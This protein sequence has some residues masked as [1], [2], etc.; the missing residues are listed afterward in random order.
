MT[1]GSEAERLFP[2]ERE[3]GTSF[4]SS[5]L[6][7]FCFSSLYCVDFD[8][9]L[10]AKSFSPLVGENSTSQPDIKSKDCVGASSILRREKNLVEVTVELPK[11]EEI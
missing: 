5:Y 11:E 1:G 4:I 10:A 6:K 2:S 8:Y 9:L 7:S 3:R